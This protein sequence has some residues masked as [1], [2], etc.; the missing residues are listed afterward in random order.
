[1]DWRIIPDLIR[2]RHDGSPTALNIGRPPASVPAF[3]P[4]VRLLHASGM[5]GMKD[6][7][8]EESALAASI[9]LSPIATILCDPH[10]PDTPIVAVNQAFCALT[11]YAEREIL[12]RN[13]RFLAGERTE[14]A[15]TERIRAAIRS[16]RP[17]V[18][19]LL[20]YRKDGTPFRNAVLI[21]PILNDS[22]G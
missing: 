5:G 6:R 16:L 9:R 18:T 19:E 8:R 20:N 22:G 13:C 11:G 17:S 3:S 21:A 15:Q 14:P 1:M 4:A 7:R 12:G 10:L 2:D